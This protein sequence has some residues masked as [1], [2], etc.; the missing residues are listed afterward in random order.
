MGTEFVGGDGKFWKW[1]G[2]WFY[3]IMKAYNATELY[4]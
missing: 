1:L 4:T 2:G 3:S